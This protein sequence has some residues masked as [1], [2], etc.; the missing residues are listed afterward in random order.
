MSRGIQIAL[1][2]LILLVCAAAFFLP[3]VKL[4]DKGTLGYIACFLSADV[5]YTFFR[6][7]QLRDLYLGTFW[8]ANVLMLASPFG[9]WRARLGKAAVFL[10][11]MVVWDLLTVSYAYYCRINHDVGTPLVGWYVWEGSLI[12]MTILLVSTRI[13]H[14][15]G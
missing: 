5:G 10:M 3:S 13:S 2:F 9:L 6:S 14:R 12:A 11:L 8:F 4:S 15:Q 7:H 1:L